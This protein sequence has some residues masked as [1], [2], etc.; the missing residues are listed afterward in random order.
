MA[1]KKTYGQEATE[2]C[3]AIKRLA[4][5]P[6]SLENLESYLSGHFQSW[7]E[8]FADTPENIAAELAAFA[9]MGV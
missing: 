8:K 9:E 7:L 5:N 4:E 2:F 6:D 3:K 1:N